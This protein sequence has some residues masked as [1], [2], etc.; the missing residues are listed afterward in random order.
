MKKQKI[1][2]VESVHKARAKSMKLID[3][4]GLS[5]LELT[6]SKTEADLRKNQN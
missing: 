5:A 2:L 6:P 4:Q 3:D 1:D